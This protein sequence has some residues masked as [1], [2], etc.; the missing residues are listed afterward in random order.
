MDPRLVAFVLLTATLV[1]GTVY[2][3]SSNT[4][5]DTSDP[6][7]TD[8]PHHLSQT[9]YFASKSNI[10]NVY[11]IKCAWAWT[12]AAFVALWATTPRRQ[13]TVV[14]R[15]LQYALAT[16]VWLGFTSWFF[17]P[18]LIERFV[19]ASGGEC[20]VSLP[21]GAIVS[22]PNEYCFTKSTISPTTHP[23]LFGAVLVLP[24]I[25]WHGRPRL[26]RG[27]D[28]SGHVFLLTLSTLFLADQLRSSLRAPSWPQAHKVALGLN[29][30]LIG[31]WMF[32]NY[33]TS[34]YFHAPFEKVTGYLL[35]LAGFA[36]TQVPLLL[37]APK[38]VKTR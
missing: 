35:G 34:V 31:V 16:A 28:V 4:Y 19:A 22:V 10:L 5:L 29:V 18:A 9:D 30:A 37:A 33:T 38:P 11:F 14:P 7:L 32:A 17:G 27:H 3:I 21:T 13:R 12:S 2:S 1:V 6:F 25:D 23:G 8:L 20:V 36:L 15:L 26:R 24:E